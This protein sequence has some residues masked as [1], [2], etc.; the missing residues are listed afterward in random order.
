MNGCERREVASM[1]AL[2]LFQTDRRQCS[3]YR[4]STV[5]RAPCSVLRGW[6]RLPRNRRHTPDLRVFPV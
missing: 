6:G 1:P 3:C 5:G 2:T 4:V